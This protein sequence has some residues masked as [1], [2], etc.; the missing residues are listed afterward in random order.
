MVDKVDKGSDILKSVRDPRTSV[1]SSTHPFSRLN[2]YFI[3]RK[4]CK[5]KQCHCVKKPGVS[6]GIKYLQVWKIIVKKERGNITLDNFWVYF[7]GSASEKKKNIIAV[8]CFGG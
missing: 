1:S 2:S 7:F 4:S 6:F 8:S 5:A 3:L